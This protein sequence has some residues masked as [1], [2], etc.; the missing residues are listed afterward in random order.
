MGPMKIHSVF[1]ISTENIKTREAACVCENCY[2]ESGFKINA[3]CI[4]NKPC[5]TKV[6][7]HFTNTDRVI[8]NEQVTESEETTCSNNSQA[9]TVEASAD[10]ILD[11]HENDYV[12]LVYDDKNY[13]GKIMECDDNDN[14]V[15]VNCMERCG[16]VEW[17]FKWPRKED[18]IW[19][20]K[21]KS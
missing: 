17:K 21:R 15:E 10:V 13:T 11:M 8:S 5:L 20:S 16:K 2:H 6:Q 19:I 14:E 7:R 1:A 12:V 9:N 18:R 4:W 3:R